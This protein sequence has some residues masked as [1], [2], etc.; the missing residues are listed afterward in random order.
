MPFTPYGD[1]AAIDKAV[2]NKFS[3]ILKR[4]SKQVSQR[5]KSGMR[6]FLEGSAKFVFTKAVILSFLY[7][8]FSAIFMVS[9]GTDTEQK[10]ITRILA[11]PYVQFRTAISEQEARDKKR[12]A[13]ATVIGAKQAELLYEKESKEIELNFQNELTP[14]LVQRDADLKRTES[15]NI[16]CRQVFSS[17]IENADRVTQLDRASAS[18]VGGVSSFF[19]YIFGNEKITRWGDRYQDQVFLEGQFRKEDFTPVTECLLAELGGDDG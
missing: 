5:P 4:K 15:A 18:L 12:V 1:E 6:E 2:S 10:T 3:G 19:G 13:Y 8:C 17:M 9:P 11:A 16:A 7:L 14:I